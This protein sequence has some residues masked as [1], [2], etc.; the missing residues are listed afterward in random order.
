MVDRRVVGIHIRVDTM[1]H[2]MQLDHLSVDIEGL[3]AYD[4]DD[5]MNEGDN[6]N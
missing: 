5:V 6:N 3:D 2:W 1:Y 4:I